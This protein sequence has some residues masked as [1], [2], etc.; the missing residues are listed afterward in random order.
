MLAAALQR[1]GQREQLG[2]GHVRSGQKVGDSGLAAGD[3]AGLV[4]RY[5][6][7]TASFFQRR[8]GLEQDAVLRTNAVAHHNSHRR[9]Q[10]Q[11]TGAADDQHRDAPR[12][13]VAHIPPQQQP[14]K[15]GDHRNA[16][17]R[18]HEKAGYGIG[19]LCNGG[20]GG[21]G[22]ADH[23]DDLRQRGVLAH[24]GSAALQI[25]G[26]VG[27]GGA[28]LIAHGLVHRDALA[29]QGT[30]VHGAAALQHNTVHRD[31]LARAHHKDIFFLHLFN[32]YGHLGTVLQQG[33]S[34]GGKLHQALER[35]GGL[36][37][38]A[39][40]Q[41]FAY[42]DEGQ[43]HG[44][45]LK[46][47]LHHVVHDQF[48]VAVQLRIG[49]GK[50]GVGTPHKACHRAH[51]HQCI[52]VGG[53][54][55]QPFEAVD[56]KLL[57]DHH[58][59]ACQQQLHQPHGNVVAV[60]PAGQR[61]APHHVSHG[62]VHQHQQKAQRGDKPPFQFGRFVVSQRVQLC[63]GA[64]GCGGLFGA[65]TVTCLLHGADNGGI[66]CGALHAHGVCQQAYRTA[67]DARHA[68][69]GL[70]Y[71]GRAGRAA[72]AGNVELFHCYF[73]LWSV[74]PA[75]GHFISLGSSRSS[76]SSFSSLPARRSSA[77]QLPICC[78]SNSREKLFSAALAAA[79]CTRMST[80]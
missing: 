55:H 69:Y 43:D 45:R 7:G 15:G 30:L 10:T 61:P 33:G 20:F 52:H 1:G 65:C 41:H 60:K 17:D 14:D 48:F 26:L 79:T 18:R 71:P 47:E 8:S 77:T 23:A 29:G 16:D 59:D 42:R 22:I 58:H 80:Q 19:D 64:G 56:E 63:A 35:I 49:H 70:F 50:Q 5:D 51:S 44:G 37:L 4:Q 72:H 73:S 66:L 27:G 25:A 3:S 53:A 13:R 12:Q 46:I 57:V 28:Y 38:G 54:V 39:C 40:L 34:F 32:G 67:G 78:A 2:F 74:C 62:K 75:G 6:A 76:S 21:G 68:L 31:V 36:A 9:C 24:A 11:R